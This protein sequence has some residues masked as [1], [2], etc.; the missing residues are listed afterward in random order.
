MNS[1]RL[2]QHLLGDRKKPRR[3]PRRRHHERYIL[4]EDAQYP[5]RPMQDAFFLFLECSDGGCGGG[6]AVWGAETAF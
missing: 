6:V 1:S 3:S 2:S 4:P 5:S